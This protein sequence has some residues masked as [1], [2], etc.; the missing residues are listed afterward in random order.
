[1]KTTDPFE[2]VTLAEHYQKKVDAMLCVRD[3]IDIE[4]LTDS[5]AAFVLY[6]TTEDMHKV[7]VGLISR[8]DLDWLEETVDLI[9]FMESLLDAD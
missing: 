3:Y 8:L 7:R 1:M 4:G 5:Q 2:I 9:K 6:T